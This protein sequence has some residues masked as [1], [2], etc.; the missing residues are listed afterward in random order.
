MEEKKNILK[1]ID[2]HFSKFNFENSKNMGSCPLKIN[3]AINCLLNKDNENQVK[4]V[5]DTIISSDIESISLSLQTI[6]IFE[7]DPKNIDEE[8]KKYILTRNTVAIMFPFI[9]SQISLLTTQPGVQP[10]LLQPIDVN[11]FEYNTT[12]E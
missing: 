7:I 11:N 6:G 8:T 4:I 3:Y 1:M 12:L 2:L 10:I 9:R 5:I